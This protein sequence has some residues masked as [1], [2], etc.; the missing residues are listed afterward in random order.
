MDPDLWGPSAWKFL[1]AIPLGAPSNK[2]SPELV[3]AYTEF[4]KLL[5]VVLPCGVCRK[6]FGE[7]LRTTEL[8]FSTSTEFADLLRR[9]HN[10]VNL[11][12]GKPTVPR[13]RLL[14]TLRAMYSDSSL[15]MVGGSGDM[16]RLL[17]GLL[18][19]VAGIVVM[20]VVIKLFSK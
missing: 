4:I 3:R 5:P 7:T 17:R 12:T 15:T 18:S 6:H 2:L 10:A 20:C 16:G 14:D 19:I 9:L 8:S 11:R 1:H 13:E